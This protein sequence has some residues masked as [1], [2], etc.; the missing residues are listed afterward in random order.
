MAPPAARRQLM[1][2]FQE[3]MQRAMRD[4]VA[5]GLHN[6]T[7][8]LLDLRD[9]RAQKLAADVADLTVVRDIVAAAEKNQSAPVLVTCA[10]TEQAAKLMRGRSRKSKS[11]FA[12]DL[13]PN[14]FRLIVVGSGGITWAVGAIEADGPTGRVVG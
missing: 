1:N 13:P 7:M 11:K 14:R 4:A 9:D 5:E 6:T 3:P 10:T 2:D 8:L 12:I